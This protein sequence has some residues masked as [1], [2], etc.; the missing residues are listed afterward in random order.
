MVVV[1]LVPRMAVAQTFADQL[2]PEQRA[3]LGLSKLTDEERAAL[4][5]AIERYKETGVAEA[6]AVVQA[7]AEEATKMAAAAAA[8][9]AVA[10]YQ[11]QE[12]PSV[13]QRALDIFKRDQEEENQERF[14]TTIP[15]KFRGWDGRTVF[16]LANGQ[17]WQ[18]ASRDT[19]YPRVVEDVPVVVYKANSGYYRLQVLDDHGA[20]VTVK[21]V[22]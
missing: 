13:I 14:T 9:A 16:H 8:A 15:G 7:E 2:S 11:E 5:G 17:V 1:L 4:F 3:A 22:R 18:Q 6:V 12:Q 21:R 19:Y 20:W 10:E